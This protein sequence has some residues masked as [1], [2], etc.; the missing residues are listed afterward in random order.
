M[1]RDFYPTISVACLRSSPCDPF[2]PLEIS[3][4]ATVWIKIHSPLSEGRTGADME[5]HV[6]VLEVIL[7]M[8]LYCLSPYGEQLSLVP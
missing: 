2:L 6:G 8:F 4:I 3:V 7:F 5:P 1:T